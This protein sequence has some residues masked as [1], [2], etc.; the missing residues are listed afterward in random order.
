[1]SDKS[2]RTAVILIMLLNCVAL[3][4]A[5]V[6]LYQR[7]A[8]HRWDGL[9]WAVPVFLNSFL[10]IFLTRLNKRLQVSKDSNV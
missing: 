7:T 3:V 10:M 9:T 5:L 1:M 6:Y 4:G 8:L 2:K